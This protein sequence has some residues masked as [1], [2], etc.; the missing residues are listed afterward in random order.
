MPEFYTR[1][2]W[3]ARARNGGPGAL[4]PHQVEGIALHWPAMRSPIRGAADV[5][6]ALRGWQ[7]YHMDTHGWSDI[8][9][10]EAIDQDG[11]VYRLRGLRNQSGANGN[12]DLN[13]RFGALL[14]V[15]A[16]GE[17]PSQAM[18]DAVH[19]R[20]REHRRHFP[21]S[22]KIVGHG[23]IRPG[24]TVCPGPIAQSMIHKGAFEP[25]K[26]EPKP[27]PDRPSK[28][29][30]AKRKIRAALAMLD[31]VPDDRKAVHARKREIRQALNRMPPRGKGDES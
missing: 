7:D 1:A 14:L 8:G 22:T 28:V 17:D 3:R 24:G 4:N 15:L 6:A 18:V 20:I 26:V 11:N 21:G 10:Q 31:T 12:S 9:Y 25:P 16:P 2:E 13:E 30:R 27:D 23:Q 5:M 19:R 29:V